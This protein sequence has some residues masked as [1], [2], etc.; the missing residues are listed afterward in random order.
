MA[1]LNISSIYTADSND[2]WTPKNAFLL[3]DPYAIVMAVQ[4]DS[5]VVSEG[6]LFDARFKSLGRPK[7][8]LQDFPGG[9]L[10]AMAT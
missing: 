7:I 6:L 9:S 2:F 1:F 3:N 10:T 4:A 5:T 8:L